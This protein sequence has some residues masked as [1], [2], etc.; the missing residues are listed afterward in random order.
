MR[1]PGSTYQQRMHGSHSADNAVRLKFSIALMPLGT[2]DQADA[3][4][5]K[6]DELRRITKVCNRRIGVLLGFHLA[7]AAACFRRHNDASVE[8]FK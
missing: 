2:C 3:A 8:Q 6:F 1:H 5:R 4:S 7:F